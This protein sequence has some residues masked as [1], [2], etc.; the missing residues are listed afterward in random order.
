[1]SD[2]IFTY[3]L[4]VIKTVVIL[5]F[6]FLASLPFVAE[7]ISGDEILSASIGPSKDIEANIML[8][9]NEKVTIVFKTEE[10]FSNSE[11]LNISLTDPQKKEFTWKKSFAASNKAGTQTIDFFSFTPETSG[12][13]RIKINNAVFQTEIKIV[14]GM[15]NPAGQLFYL[16]A[17]LIS[18]IVTLAGA[19]LLR[20]N[21]MNS[22][23]FSL[24]G[25]LN[26]FISLSL[27]L[28]IVNKIVGL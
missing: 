18:L 2:N 21:G 8:T 6:V 13:Y 23:N 10:L 19:F 1:M 4:K 22:R 16:P 28:I 26:F 24:S 11:L 9:E 17:L 20:N 12:M 15:I 5:N 25:A 7:Y 27:S 14:S 3:I